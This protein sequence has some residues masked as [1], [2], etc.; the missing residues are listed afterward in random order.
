MENNTTIIVLGHNYTS[1]LGI[2]RAVGMA[3][4][5]V[6]VIATLKKKPK[7][8]PIDFYSK[9]TS[10]FEYC[11]RSS[12]KELVSLLLQNYTEHGK[13]SILIPTDDYTAHVIDNAYDTLFPHFIMPSIREK[14]GEI[15]RLMDKHL[16]KQYA[17]QA[18]FPVVKCWEIDVKDGL[19]TIPKDVE[20]PCFTKPNVSV[21]GGKNEYMQLCRC[22]KDLATVLNGIAKKGDCPM[23]I[24][25]YVEIEKEYAVLGFRNGHQTS[26][27]YVLYLLEQGKGGHKGVMLMGK[28]LPMT[29]FKGLAEKI[30]KM[31]EEIGL[32]GLFDVDLYESN[33]LIYFNELNLRIGASAYAVTRTGANLPKMY[34]QSVLGLHVTPFNEQ[35]ERK[36]MTFLNEK[37]NLESLVDRH[38][39]WGQYKK[40][41]R[42]ADDFFIKASNDPKPYWQFVVY[43]YYMRLKTFLFG[44]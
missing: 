24:E 26:V 30:E 13:K 23:L 6:R 20:Y 18:G 4:Y 12:D 17:E 43:S 11:L 44:K 21:L 28:V 39:T 37:L 19:F 32:V 16:Q 35:I 38:L 3:G 42:N 2:V 27:P 14:Q 15:S 40:N 25:Q 10:D 5:R 34:I 33:G 8:H 1:R 36:D 29:Q 7:R 31:L 9:F 41:I 22:E